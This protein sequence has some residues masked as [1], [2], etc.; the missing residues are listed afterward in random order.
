[1]TFIC[2]ISI[3]FSIYPWYWAAIAGFF[4]PFSEEKLSFNLTPVVKY[5]SAAVT[6]Q[7]PHQVFGGNSHGWN[8]FRFSFILQLW[9]V[10]FNRY[11]FVEKIELAGKVEISCTWHDCIQYQSVHPSIRRSVRPWP[12]IHPSANPFFRHSVDQFFSPCIIWSVCQSVCFSV[13][14]YVCRLHWIFYYQFIVCCL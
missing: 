13:C 5:S 14:F 10:F 12:F 2:A 7:C 11:V 3:F 4:A 1:M 8:D 9:V 6:A